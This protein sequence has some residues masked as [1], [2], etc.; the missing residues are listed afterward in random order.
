MPI[1]ERDYELSI[2]VYRYCKVRSH[3]RF[4]RDG[5][6]YIIKANCTAEVRGTILYT[7]GVQGIETAINITANM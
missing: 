4:Q 1:G 6:V 2:F 5:V 7:L 3:K